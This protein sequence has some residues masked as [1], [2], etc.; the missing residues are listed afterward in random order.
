MA[1]LSYYQMNLDDLTNTANTA[2]V[3]IIDGLTKEGYITKEQNKEVL[4]QY[5]VIAKKKSFWK[6]IITKGNDDH[7]M[8]QFLKNC[9][10]KEQKIQEDEGPDGETI[11]DLTE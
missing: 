3:A 1:T 4:E 7:P 5:F 2:M 8:Y 10:T 11:E 9:N 6:R